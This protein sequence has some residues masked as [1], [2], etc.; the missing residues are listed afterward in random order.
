MTVQMHDLAAQQSRDGW[1]IAWAPHGGNSRIHLLDAR[2]NA[3]RSFKLE[4]SLP[5]FS[6]FAHWTTAGMAWSENMLAYFTPGQ[7]RL[8][9]R[10]WWGARL[11]IALDQLRPIDPQGLAD[12]L[13]DAERELVLRGLHRLVAATE[14][15]EQVRFDW[16]STEATYCT[17][18]TLVHFP[19]LLGLVEA[20]PLLR[21]LE[22]RLVGSGQCYSR[23]RYCPHEDRLLAQISLRRLGEKPRGYPALT[24]AESEERSPLRRPQPGPIDG[25]TRHTKLAR[26][27]RSSPLSEVYEQLGAPDEVGRGA[28]RNFW[29]YDVDVDPPYTV[30]LWLAGDDA[31]TRI[32]RYLPPFW[33]GPDVFPSRDHSLLG[34]DGTTVD[35][36]L[37]ELD[38]G[39]FAGARIEVDV[40]QEVASSGRD[41]LAPL[42]QA[43]LDGAYEAL[44]PLADALEEAGDA[45]APQVRAWVKA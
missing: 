25:A 5:D 23:F 3:L 32:V 17:V 6:R 40:L 39:T 29:R 31:V 43:V 41:P 7:R 35:A 10:A 12:E 1:T 24:F 26:I 2:G 30:L 27:R 22:E 33:T 15:G 36:Y 38:D 19:G 42:A 21:V 18:G 4:S 34:S 45:R 16:P 44:G 9:V 8:V 13:R 37:K 11:V 14:N 20:V 28:G